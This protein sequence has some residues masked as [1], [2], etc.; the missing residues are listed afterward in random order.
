TTTTAMA[1]WVWS[2]LGKDP[3]FIIGGISQNLGTNAHAGQGSA[4]IIE[5]DEY[6]RMFHGLNPDA[7]VVTNVEHDHPDCFPTLESYQEAFNDFVA[8]LRLGGFALFCADDPLAPILA[9]ALPAGCTAFTYGLLGGSDYRAGGVHTNEFGGLTFLV[10]FRGQALTEIVLRVPGEHNVRN[11]LAVLALAHR[12]GLDEQATAR[13]L[14]EFR[15]TQRRF[16]LRGEAGGVT[17]IDDYAHHPTE[18]RATLAAARQRYP[19]RRI[20]AVWQP[21]T[22]TRIAALKDDFQ[23]AF[24]DADQVLVTDVFAARAREDREKFSIAAMVAEMSHPSARFCPT[25]EKASACLQDEL[26]PGDVLLV[27]SA[28]DADRIS[29]QVLEFLEMKGI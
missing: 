29:T 10:S 8:R 23:H 22:F 4:F 7:I 13:A 28:G 3:S 1:A 18:I 14:S 9:A 21:H 19:G 24:A 16:E 17:V 5:A 25:L 27:L 2:T 11:A 12:M 20:W 26:R 15:G 6:D